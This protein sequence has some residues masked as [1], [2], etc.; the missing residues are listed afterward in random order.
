MNLFKVND[1]WR[2]GPSKKFAGGQVVT[3]SKRGG[4]KAR[5]LLQPLG[6]NGKCNLAFDCKISVLRIVLHLARFLR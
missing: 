2:G 4:W 3:V 1:T 5:N 6:E